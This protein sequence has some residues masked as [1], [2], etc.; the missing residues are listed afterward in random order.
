MDQKPEIRI[1]DRLIRFL[2]MAEN[3]LS[4]AIRKVQ[5][6]AFGD[7]EEYAQHVI[8]DVRAVLSALD[9]REKNKT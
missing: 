3:D 4:T 1:K 9:N 6:G 5:E 8:N 2:E 7:A